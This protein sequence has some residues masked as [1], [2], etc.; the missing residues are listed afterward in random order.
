[1]SLVS[2]RLGWASLLAMLGLGLPCCGPRYTG[3][4]SEVF[5]LWVLARLTAPHQSLDAAALQA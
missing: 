4:A 5:E 1:M 3:T 2:H